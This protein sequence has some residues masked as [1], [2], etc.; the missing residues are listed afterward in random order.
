MIVIP[1]AYFLFN[2]HNRCKGST[3]DV[4]PGSEGEYFEEEGRIITREAYAGLGIGV[5]V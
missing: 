3:Q 4:V 5:D 1:K 2:I